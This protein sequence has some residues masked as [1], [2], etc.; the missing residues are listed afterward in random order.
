MTKDSTLLHTP[1]GTPVWVTGT[2]PSVILIH[3]V[4]MDH[5]MWAAQVEALAPF[6]RVC[7]MDM[8]GHGDAP[9]PA[10]ARTLADFVAQVDDVVQ[11]ISPA[12]KPVLG[13]F[14]MGGLVTQAYAIK[15]HAKL[16]G[17]ML[18][19][20]VYDRS[21]AQQQTVRQRSAEMLAGGAASAVES[22]NSRWFTP[23]DRSE[24]AEKIESIL[25][26][27]R[28]GDFSAK[29]KA[30]R[31]FATSDGE[32]TGRLGS[33]ACPALV[34]TGDGDAG[35][36]AAMAEQMASEIPNAQLHV[37]DQQRHMMPIFD[38]ARVNTHVLA[39]LASIFSDC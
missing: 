39:Y 14:S 29:V 17:V 6:Y 20:A 32:N 21:P 28:D 2:G 11:L 13:G 38:A 27:M 8:L 3:G 34:M 5:R 22:A 37:L 30:H 19:N 36:T 4:L 24:R 33:I 10:G 15:H 9:D 1:N 18:F 12:D 31:V 7:C 16:S 25:D 26:W 23:A 35:S